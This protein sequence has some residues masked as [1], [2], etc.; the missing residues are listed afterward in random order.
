M[1][2]RSRRFADWLLA[3]RLNA[4]NVLAAKNRGQLRH[5]RRD[6]LPNGVVSTWLADD[7]QEPKIVDAYGAHRFEELLQCGPR[8]TRNTYLRGDRRAAVQ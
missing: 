7:G 1:D 8:W 6:H 5:R 4:G 2:V 3:T